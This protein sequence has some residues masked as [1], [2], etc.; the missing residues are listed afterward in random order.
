MNSPN[1][2]VTLLRI[3]PFLTVRN[4]T[5]FILENDKETAVLYNFNP[6]YYVGNW[7]SRFLV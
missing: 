2:N 4:P 1:H 3:S 5:T 7:F 6:V